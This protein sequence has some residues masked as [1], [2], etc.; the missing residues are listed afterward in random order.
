MENTTPIMFPEDEAFD[1]GQDTRSG[2]AMIEYRYDV[3]FKFTGKIE[4]VVVHLGESKL[5]DSDQ[6][7][8][9]RMEQKARLAVE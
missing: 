5:S 9:Q 2:V 4:K 6:Q 3:P 1:V 8:I 7:K